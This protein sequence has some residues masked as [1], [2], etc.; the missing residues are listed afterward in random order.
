[1]IKRDIHD[2]DRNN[3][4]EFNLLHDIINPSKCIKNTNY[5]YKRILHRYINTQRVK[6]NYKKFQLLL[7]STCSNSM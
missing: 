5:H 6:A 7:E 4:A 2:N 3:I 1:M